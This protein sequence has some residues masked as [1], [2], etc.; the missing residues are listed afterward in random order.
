VKALSIA[1]VLAFAAAGAVQARPAAEPALLAYFLGSPF[2]APGGGGLCATPGPGSPSIR[3]TDPI[4]AQ[5]PTWSPDGRRVAYFR[6]DASF[7]DAQVFVAD[8]DGSRAV[9]VTVRYRASA[10]YPAWSP[11][12]SRIAFVLRAP[13]GSELVTIAPDGSDL[14]PVAGSKTSPSGAM[15]VPAW[16]PDGEKLAFSMD[17]VAIRGGLFV[18]DAR[19]GTP[20]LLAPDS[21]GPAWSPDGS[22]LAYTHEGRE[23]VVIHGDGTEPRVLVTARDGSEGVG[24]PAWSPDGRTIAFVRASGRDV[25][26]ETVGMDGT[27]ERVV[28]GD[29]ELGASFPAW[30]P[31]GPLRQPVARPC[32]VRGTSHA[33]RLVGT[34]AGDV[35]LGEGGDDLM[36]GRGGS[37][38]ILPGYGKD[39]VQ[40]GRGNDWIYARDG[41]ADRLVGGAGVDRTDADRVDRLRSIERRKRPW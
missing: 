36:L 27:G 10:S 41:Q 18:I 11:D 6:V 37:D 1:V 23:I 17:D 31:A 8:A 38:L 5:R 2:S 12:G 20:R 14:R 34:P 26:V 33:D 15:S 29:Q 30:R 7:E 4:N 16:S 21:G 13:S 28:A 39:D 19:G 24:Q 32:V 25:L 40:G 3:L 35:L 9:D 22:E